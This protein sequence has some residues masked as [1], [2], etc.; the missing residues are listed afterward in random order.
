MTVNDTRA[1]IGDDRPSLWNTLTVLIELMWRLLVWNYL[2]L[3][4]AKYRKAEVP[5]NDAVGILLR[6]AMK[7][8]DH[9]QIR[10]VV[11]SVVDVTDPKT[12]AGEI[13]EVQSRNV[14][15]KILL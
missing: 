3:S 9:L 15:G 7:V 10:P 6:D 11:D 5:P 1:W 13:D 2:E 14:C 4:G 8:V 12:L